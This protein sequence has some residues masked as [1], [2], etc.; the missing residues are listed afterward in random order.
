MRS[1]G[2]VDA[3]RGRR[4]TIVL[5]VAAALTATATAVAATGA[6]PRPQ[7]LDY[8]VYVGGKGR[9]NPRL[10]PVTIGFINQQGGPPN[11]NRPQ[12][13]SV[14]RAGVRMV[15]AELGGIHGHPLRLTEC[16]VAEAEEEGVRCGQQFAN[17]RNV[18]AVLFGF[19]VNGNQ[20]LYATLRGTKPVIGGVTATASDPT[21]RNAYFLNGSQTSVLGPFGTYTQR[22][23]R[24]VRTVAIVYPNQPGADTAA[25]ALRSAMQRVGRQVTMVATQPLATDLLGAATQASS[26]DMIVPALGFTECVPF[27]RALEQIR[28]TKPVLST[29]LC[30]AIPRAAYAGGDLPKWTYGIAQ[31][32]VNLPGPQSS[33]FLRKGLQ[34]GTTVNDMLWVFSEIAWEELLATVKIMNRIP[35]AQLTPARISAGFKAFRGPLVLAAPEV[36]CGKVSPR[37][38]A[39]CGNQ[40]QFYTY[41]GQGKWKLASGWL[42]PPTGG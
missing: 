35:Y 1:A 26:A 29:P 36:A 5:A 22:A 16:F 32:L 3:V 10:A 13:T 31:T 24:N 27:A 18:K 8:Q 6:A 37:E 14:I 30:T 33:L 34:Y 39:V 9:A 17:D 41:L 25:F 28:Y 20:S 40:T 38:P 15:N 11:V 2:I 19:L 12:A 23:L 21:A 7:V 42:K 4:A